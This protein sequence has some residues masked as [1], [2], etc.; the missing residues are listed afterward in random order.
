MASPPSTLTTGHAVRLA[1]RSKALTGP[2]AGLAPS[3]LQA[4]LIVLP[5]QYAADFRL[6][7]ARN[8]VPCPLLAESSRPG[9][10]RSLRSYVYPPDNTNAPSPSPRPLVLAKDI[11]LRTDAPAYRVFRDGHLVAPTD[12]DPTD[13]TAA[14]HATDHVAFLIGCSFSF[15]AALHTAGLAPRHVAQNRNVPMYRAARTPLL[16]AGVFVGGVHVVSMRPYRAS[17]IERVRAVTRRFGAAHGEPLAWGWGAVQA[18]GIKDMQCPEWGDAPLTGGGSRVFG[19]GVEEDGEKYVPVFWGC[20]VT[21]QEAVVCANLSGTVMGHAPGCMVV[22][23]VTDE[24][25]FAVKGM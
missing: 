5:S 11:D 19:E 21:P 1:A 15:D 23:D 16:P 10:F 8:P 2:T 3:Y 7:C 25:V 24:E 13:I 14:W 20:G 17:E 22:L 12:T 18:L 6:L 4:N 9:A